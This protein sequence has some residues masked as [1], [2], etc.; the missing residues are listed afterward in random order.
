VEPTVEENTDFAY[1]MKQ[2]MLEKGTKLV[3][4]KLAEYIKALKDGKLISFILRWKLN[5]VDFTEYSQGLI[6]PKKDGVETKSDKP[7]APSAPV[8]LT[9]QTQVSTCC[10]SPPKF[11][12]MSFE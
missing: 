2:L 1:A 9:S 10:Y 4:E 6:L 5:L 12:N 11:L 7:S 8:K 3:R